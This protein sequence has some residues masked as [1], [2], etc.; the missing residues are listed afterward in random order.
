[1]T[2]RGQFSTFWGGINVCRM[3]MDVAGGDGLPHC[4][5]RAGQLLRDGIHVMRRAGRLLLLLMFY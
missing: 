5:G 4:V 1:M 3:F 2:A